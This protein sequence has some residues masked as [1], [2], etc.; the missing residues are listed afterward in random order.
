MALFS[1]GGGEGGFRSLPS[2]SF[3]Y[4]KV[5]NICQRYFLAF[6]CASDGTLFEKSETERLHDHFLEGWLGI[7]FMNS[8]LMFGIHA[9]RPHISKANKSCIE[10]RL[11]LQ[12]R[13]VNMQYRTSQANSTKLFP[14]PPHPSSILIFFKVKRWLASQPE[15]EAD[16]FIYRPKRGRA[17]LVQRVTKQRSNW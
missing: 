10:W 1:A 17:S 8:A 16:W 11:S 13:L 3:G 15:L 14:L 7:L 12:N 4:L 9:K 2:R 6:H 5:I